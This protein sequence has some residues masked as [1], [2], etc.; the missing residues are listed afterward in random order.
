MPGLHWLRYSLV[1]AV[2]VVAAAGV[3]AGEPAIASLVTQS[4]PRLGR[5]IGLSAPERRA[6]TL[7][8]LSAAGDDSLGLIVTARF[9][10]DV[11]DRLGQRGLEH[12][13]LALTLLRPRSARP[14]GQLLSEGGGSGATRLT[15]LE[16][17]GGYVLVKHETFVLFTPDR[18][19]DTAGARGVQVIRDRDEAVFYVPARD[20][21]GVSRSGSRSSPSLQSRSSS[22]R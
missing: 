6:I 14:A 18:N 16:R 1:V 15:L 4:A 21:T 2:V 10:G 7:T 8:S 22:P 13:L 20:L 19:V 11:G 17:H 9:A 5:T 12:G 3:S